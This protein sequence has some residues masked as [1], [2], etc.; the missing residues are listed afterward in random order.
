MRKAAL[1]C[2]TFMSG[3]RAFI[4][5]PSILAIVA[6]VYILGLLRF[7]R[8]H[9]AGGDIP[10]SEAS[11]ALDFPLLFKSWSTFLANH[12]VSVNSRQLTILLF[13]SF[14]IYVYLL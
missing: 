4:S 9:T 3:I 6:Q 10:S 14:C 11:Q 5:T 12:W 2:Y 7:R 8:I 1:I 13:L